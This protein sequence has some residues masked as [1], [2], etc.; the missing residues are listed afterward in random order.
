L[1]RDRRFWGSKWPIKSLKLVQLLEF[2][3]DRNFGTAP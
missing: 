3:P 2:D 1:L